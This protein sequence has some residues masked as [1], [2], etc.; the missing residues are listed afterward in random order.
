MHDT[1]EDIVSCI[2]LYLC[3]TCSNEFSRDGAHHLSVLLRMNPP[4]KELVLSFNRIEDE[5]LVWISQ[6]IADN[7]SNLEK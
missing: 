2:L 3:F 7:N 4:L 1:S 6:A 5:G